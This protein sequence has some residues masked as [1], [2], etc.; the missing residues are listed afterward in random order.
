MDQADPEGTDLV[1]AH[2]FG[3]GCLVLI[4]TLPTSLMLPMRLILSL[5]I[6][7]LRM[8]TGKL[9]LGLELPAL[10]GEDGSLT[11]QASSLSSDTW[12][13]KV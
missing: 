5:K 10:H 3:T 1:I 4:K 12:G 11:L 8:M 13:S 2:R 9:L 7:I 6:I